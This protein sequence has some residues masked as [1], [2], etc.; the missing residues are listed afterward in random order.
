MLF[1]ALLGLTSVTH[2]QGTQLESS[3]TSHSGKSRANSRSKHSHHHPPDYQ[4]AHT[5]PR[6]QRPC[7]HGPYIVDALERTD[8]DEIGEGIGRNSEHMIRTMLFA[9]AFNLS[10]I[11]NPE[12]FAS[13]HRTHYEW[14]FDYELESV[15]KQC[16]LTD[17]ASHMEQINIV[18]VSS[19]TCL[20][21]NECE[22]MNATHMIMSEEYCPQC[23][24]H[25]ICF[26]FCSM[27]MEGTPVTADSINELLKD[28]ERKGLV[29]DQII[30]ALSACQK[31]G[32][33]R[34]TVLRLHHR[35]A[36]TK[37]QLSCL[38]N[39][40]FDFHDSFWAKRRADMS[41]LQSSDIQTS[42]QSVAATSHDSTPATLVPVV[43]R[44][45]PPPDCLAIA[46]MY[47]AGDRP[48]FVQ[49]NK[50]VNES[51]AVIQRLFSHPASV[52]FQFDRHNCYRVSF[53]SECPYEKKKGYR[54]SCDESE[55]T[56]VFGTVID[57]FPP[58][59]LS[60]RL[61]HSQH[62]EDLDM[63][64]TSDILITSYSS[65]HVLGMTVASD[66]TLVIPPTPVVRVKQFMSPLWLSRRNEERWNALTKGG[67]SEAVKAV[68][69][70]SRELCIR[71]KRLPEVRRRCDEY[72]KKHDSF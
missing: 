36:A 20:P 45:S 72:L 7:T 18:E 31:S 43:P 6:S 32:T 63:I 40:R 50:P 68:R 8:I 35:R 37:F 34:H 30:R 70:L 19:L 65:F 24:H 41:Y 2:A 62:L 5:L 1:V 28:N 59:V 10:Y 15:K 29:V 23:E 64:A 27:N 14:M 49:F 33:C 58:G 26:A 16:T 11:Y 17:L 56:S 39:T 61:N 53:F 46:Y 51:V 60:L 48:N 3:I 67:Q 42:T 25:E 9:S 54:P 44:Y 12:W 4:H 47:R 66:A 55:A 52:L 13:L 21:I 22:F 38:S 57:S 71:H 69:L